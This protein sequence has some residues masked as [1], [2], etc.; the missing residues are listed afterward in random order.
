[1]IWVGAKPV[2]GGNIKGKTI[3]KKNTTV[4]YQNNYYDP[5]VMYNPIMYGVCGGLALGTCCNM[6]D[7]GF[8]CGGILGGCGG[9]MGGGFANCGVGNFFGGCGGIGG[10]GGG[11]GGCGGAGCGGGC[12]GGG[13][14]GG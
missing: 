6:Y 12:G 4:V 13:C 14:G 1:M 3:I 5:L 2:C 7:V 8:Y 11:V 10:C 9:C